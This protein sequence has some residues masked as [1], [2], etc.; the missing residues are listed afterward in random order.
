M[1][2]PLR[3]SQLHVSIVLA[4]TLSACSDRPDDSPTGPQLSTGQV[5][6][7]DP[8]GLAVAVRAQ[9]RHTA[10]LLA[11]PGVVGTAVGLDAN[12][13]AIVKLFAE[14]PGIAGLPARLDDVPV[15]VEVTGRIYARTD[16]TTRVRP[17]PIGFSVGHPAITAGTIGA[18]VL[19]GS[20]NAYILSN[21][22]VLANANSAQ[23]GDPAL[24]PGPIDGGT[25]PG[26]R[27]GTL[28]AFEPLKLA[29]G[30]YGVTPPSNW[31]DA[32]IALVPIAS[33]LSNSTPLDE[34]GYGVPSSALAGDPDGDGTMDVAGL[35]GIGAQKY[36]RTTK[37]TA[38]T[39]SEINVT[40]DVCYDIFC[41][42]V[43]RFYDQV[44]ICC[45]A[46]S[47]G[48]DSGSLIVTTGTGKNPVGLLFAGGGN[49]TYANRIDRV[50]NR[51]GVT[52]DGGTSPP[53][54]L[55]DVAVSSLSAPASATQGQAVT[56]G[57]TLQNIGNQ[58]VSGAFDV[59]LS[60]VT[61]NVTIGT[62]TVAAGF[63]A[64]ASTTLD[65]TWNTT[66][67]SLG[68]HILQATHALADDNAGNDSRT[69]TVTLNQPPSGNGTI[70][71]GDLDGDRSSQ[72]RTWTA[73]ITVVVHD[74]LHGPVSAATVSGAFSAGAK[75]AG[76]C[77]TGSAG[78]CTIVK[79]RLRSASVT[80][81]VGNVT[82]SGLT[83]ASASN[84]DSD[85]GSQAS[86]G[87]TITV[88]HP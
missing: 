9:E 57:V 79:S 81:T 60:D 66:G 35:L 22:H 59:T 50:L 17:A 20:G 29:L 14:K 2:R 40:I 45:A 37:L 70:H 4:F 47:D 85:S 43:G 82:R 68:S 75:G 36:G 5:A 31:I 23:I 33:N 62:R 41:L 64:G 78:S 55:T 51:F 10:R 63:A 84:H 13:N 71:V 30:G 69:T 27:L 48:G 12:G 52:I 39:V 54:P 67:R 18:K 25:D 74:A 77:V 87:T 49:R 16:P 58:T 44:A 21:N 76:S 3:L 1:C 32:A 61:D 53:P 26:D 73:I 56:V 88:A 72:G 34:G 24:Q 46:F 28:A 83:Y 42:F 7:S 19:D 11:T 80:F 38:G 86:N 65:F 8:P 6:R 15:A